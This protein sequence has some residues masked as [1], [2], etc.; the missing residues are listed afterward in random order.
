MVLFAER[1]VAKRDWVKAVGKGLRDD[2]GDCPTLPAEFLDLIKI[3]RA[4]GE[5][6]TSKS[7]KRGLEKSTPYRSGA[8][9]V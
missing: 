7:A 3:A 9:I 8:G 6:P 4:N 5:T 2:L 1:I